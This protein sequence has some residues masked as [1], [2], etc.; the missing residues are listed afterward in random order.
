MQILCRK[1][2]E[3]LYAKLRL[4]KIDAFNSGVMEITGYIIQKGCKN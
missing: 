1:C 2:L 4:N 3:F